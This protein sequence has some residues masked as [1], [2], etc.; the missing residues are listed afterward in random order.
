MPQQPQQ[1]GGGADN[2]MAPVWI[3]VALF[4]AAFFIWKFAHQ[5]IVSFLFQLNLIQAKLLVH[6]IHDAQLE[7][8]IYIMQTIDPNSVDWDQFIHLSRSIGEFIRYPTIFLLILLALLLFRSNITLR[9]RKT[10]SMNTLRKQEQHNWLAIMPVVK[11]DLIDTD[12]TK[13]PWAMALSPMEFARKYNLLKKEDI[14]LDN[15]VSG[16]ELTA[17]LKKGDAKRVL[18]LQL[19]PYWEGFSSCSPH[20]AAL[21]AVF[22]ARI[23]RDRKSAHLILDTLDKT[24][25]MGKLD[26]SVANPI[27][28]KYENTELVQEILARHGYLLTVMGSLLAAARADG[29]VPTAEFLWLRPTDRRLWYMLNCIGRQTPFAEVAGPFAHWR[30]EKVMQRKSLMPMI[31]EAITALELAIKEI[32]LTPQELAALES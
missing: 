32:K 6:F 20:A 10:H 13:G 19:G 31:D 14:L 24:Y 11:E 1:Q 8:N 2:S 23:N 17:G 4:L 27:L 29:V 25:S 12:I 3:M 18:T 30:A 28:K 21:A 16:Q 5:Y 9:F 15:P 22:M 26:C 7:N